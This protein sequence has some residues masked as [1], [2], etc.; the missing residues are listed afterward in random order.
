MLFS[1][2]V[3]SAGETVEIAIED[4][5][6]ARTVTAPLDRYQG[7]ELLAALAKALN[8]LPADQTA[9]LHLQQPCL[10]SK[11]PIFQVGL[12]GTGE[13]VLSIRPDPI[14]PIEFDFNVEGA[15]ELIVALRKAL[16][17]PTP[18]AATN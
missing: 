8:E 18:S 5:N 15:S 11:N 4:A 10:R 1:V 6:L 12:R 17:I 2:S 16:V 3:R 13:I 7:F 9:P 14:P